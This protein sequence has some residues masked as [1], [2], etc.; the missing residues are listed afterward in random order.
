M[1]NIS[2]LYLKMVFFYLFFFK[3]AVQ[4]TSRIIRFIL[5]WTLFIKPKKAASVLLLKSYRRQ[6]HNQ[7]QDQAH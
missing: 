7:S 3:S 4:L 6:A 5:P 1:E 2:I